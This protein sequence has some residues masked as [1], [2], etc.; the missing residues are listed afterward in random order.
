MM[1]IRRTVSVLT[2]R[3]ISLGIIR[4]TTK[5]RQLGTN[6]AYIFLWRRVY[7]ILSMEGEWKNS[8]TPE[9]ISNGPRKQLYPIV[10]V[11][12]RR[13]YSRSRQKKKIKKIQVGRFYQRTRTVQRSAQ[14]TTIIFDRKRY[15]YV[16]IIVG[17]RKSD[18]L[19]LC[20]RARPKKVGLC[21]LS[22][23]A[24]FVCLLFIFFSRVLRGAR[25]VSTKT[26]VYLTPTESTPIK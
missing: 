23:N 25:R 9:S 17:E 11:S 7:D 24:A 13:R 15:Y 3:L 5:P 18:I 8:T 14:W 19:I 20:T 10:R 22:D 4:A 26:S 2:I 12:A 16:Y 6:A 21:R 1:N